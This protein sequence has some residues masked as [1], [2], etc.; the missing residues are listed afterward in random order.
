MRL[1]LA[2]PN[3]TGSITELMGAEARRAASPTTEIVTATARFGTLYVENRAEAAIAAH[4]VLELLA[5]HAA[6]CH[7]AVIAAF[8]DPGL[9]AARELLD[10]PVVGL[11]EAALLCAWP[12]GRRHSIICLTPR[13]R[14][15][16]MECAAE[17]GLAGRLASVRALAVPVPDITRA[18]E[19]LR[20]QLLEQCARAVEEDE[21]EVLIIGG[22]PLAGLA[23]EA[24]DRI[25][26]PTLDPVSCAVRLAE[27]L[28]ALGPRPPARGSFA[29]PPGKPSTGLSPALARLLAGQPPATP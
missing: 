4:A 15:W 10:I 28:V 17:H 20:E 7:A 25:P 8:G 12:L 13:L 2:N 1:L 14:T 19:N 6:G 3:V 24:A 21:A 16:Y 27:A 29:R 9:A 18:R 23:R 22:G 11:T 5:D 26:V